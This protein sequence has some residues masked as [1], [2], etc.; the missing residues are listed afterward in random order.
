MCEV[1]VATKKE[2]TDLDVNQDV[3][4]WNQAKVRGELGLFYM[5]IP[6]VLAHHSVLFIECQ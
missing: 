1:S 6:L 3:Y 4:P 2:R 5:A